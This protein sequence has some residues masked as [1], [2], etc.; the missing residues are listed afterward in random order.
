MQRP[1]SECGSGGGIVS[2]VTASRVAWR[3]GDFDVCISTIDSVDAELLP[4][5]AIGADALLL[6]ARAKLRTQ[7]PAEVLEDLGSII[8]DFRGLDERY[9]ARMLYAS[10]YARAVDPSEGLSLL[11]SVYLE[12]RRAHPS[13]RAEIS[14]YQALALWTVSRYTEADERAKETETARVDVLAVRATELRGYCAFAQG[15][16]SN[17]LNLF[18]SAQAAY[19]RCRERDVDLAAKIVYQVANLEQTLCSATVRGT[20]RR[21]HARIIPGDAFGSPS[22][23]FA[24]IRTCQNDGW[25]YALDGDAR[26]AF[27]LMREAQALAPSAAWQVGALSNSALLALYFG[28]T[29]SAEQLLMVAQAKANQ[30]DWATIRGEERTALLDLVEALCVSRTS[31]PGPLLATYD[32]DVLGEDL[33]S[34]TS[35]D[36]FLA[37]WV[38]Y[39]RGHVM[40]VNGDAVAARRAFDSAYRQFRANGCI[41]RAVLALIE[42]DA[43]PTPVMSHNGFH[44]ETAAQL[45]KEHFPNS[46]LAIRIGRWGNL[47]CD[48]IAR[49][50]TPVQREVLRYAL[51]G[52]GAVEIAALTG[53]A[54]KTV[55]KHLTAL[56][57]AFGVET[58]L[59]LVAVCHARGLGSPAWRYPLVVPQSATG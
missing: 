31:S 15:R 45:V 18:R 24:R 51:D 39:V 13:V 17:A 46:F 19:A 58:T 23:S 59:R 35:V 53:R 56:H 47:Y 2:A 55:R 22:R 32:A 14:Y 50:L 1:T 41:W 40:R 44:L 3:R 33:L 37:A 52:H 10:A 48:P 49:S 28:E 9:T 26:R 11:N 38:E 12:A 43:T 4:Q 8:E 54:E 36:P 34:A 21:P 27:T 20:H 25:L 16:Y 42:L 57:E 5:T 7:R 6:R 30:L 29:L